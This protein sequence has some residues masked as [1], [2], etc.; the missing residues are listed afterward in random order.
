M[1]ITSYAQNFE[2]VILW[3]ALGHIK[4]GTYIDVGAQHPVVDS[5]SKAFYERGWRGVH[6]EPVPSYAALLR[7]DRP[8]ETVLQLALSDRPGVLDLNVIAGTGLSTGV[9]AYASTHSSE[10]GFV[11]EVVKVPMLPMST[12]LASLNGQQVHWL[13]IDVEGFEEQVLLG[14]DSKVLRPWI[15]VIEATVPLS[16]ELNYAKADRLLIDAGYK[17]AY[18]DGLN[19]F[20]TASEHMELAHKLQL[21]PNVFDSAELSGTASSVWCRGLIGRHQQALK[22][23]REEVT[24]SRVRISDLDV[25]FRRAVSGEEQSRALA[26]ALAQQAAQAEARAAQ[27]GTQAEARIMQAEARVAQAETRAA[28]AETQLEIARQYSEAVLS[29]TSWRITAPLRLAGN[30]ARRLRSVVR[31]GRLISGLKRRIRTFL[32]A[33]VNASARHPTLRLVAIRGVALVPTLERRLRAIVAGSSSAA[34]TTDK[35]KD[36]EVHVRLGRLSP[37]ASV[38]FR[39]LTRR[40]ERSEGT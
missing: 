30:F 26:V 32:H 19:R 10:H 29:S 15:I 5:V 9:K 2:D 27:A 4:N 23:L 25:Q 37:D 21:P 6:V 38:L 11:T 22:T 7:Q 16:A 40:Q 28:L 17:F 24:A 18:F 39:Q 8:D 33:V 12:A 31:D 34:P 20:Y 14:W 3:R 13:K 35:D 36:Q 1:T